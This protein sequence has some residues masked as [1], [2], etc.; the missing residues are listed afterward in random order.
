MVLAR[1]VDVS[2]DMSGI[3]P[4]ALAAMKSG[5]GGGNASLAQGGGVAADLGMVEMA[6]RVAEA[7]LFSL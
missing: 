6:L 7:A 2:K 3:L 4:K 5:K 1:S